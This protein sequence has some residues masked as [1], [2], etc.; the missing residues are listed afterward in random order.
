MTSGTKKSDFLLCFISIKCRR[1]DVNKP[2]SQPD[3]GREQLAHPRRIR[4]RILE[5]NYIVRKN[6]RK[7]GGFLLS[8]ENL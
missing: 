8:C 1:V 4:A 7:Y 5:E 6:V 2:M 3:T